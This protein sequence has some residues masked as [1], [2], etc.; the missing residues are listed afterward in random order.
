MLWKQGG[1]IVDNS[2]VAG[3]QAAVQRF[4]MFDEISLQYCSF[5]E[6]AWSK[7]WR[8]LKILEINSTLCTEKQV[9]VAKGMQ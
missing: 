6:A 7:K 9:D 3:F 4:P 5:L 1:G 2:W 8:N